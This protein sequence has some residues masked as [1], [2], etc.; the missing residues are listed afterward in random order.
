MTNLAELLT[1][2][3][4]RGIRMLATGEDGLTIDAPQD[5][6]TPDLMGRL[7]ARKGELLAML[8]PPLGFR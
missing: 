1:D 4:A 3:D 2:C 8:Q 7:K 6:L 5:A